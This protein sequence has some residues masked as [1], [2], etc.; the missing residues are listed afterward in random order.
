[1]VHLVD[2]REQLSWFETKPL[3][4]WRVLVPRTKDQAGDMS[5]RLRAY[6][7][8]P[9][10][11][12][13]DDLAVREPVPDRLLDFLAEMEFRTLA[14]RVA[15]KLGREAPAAALDPVAAPGRPKAAAAPL[16]VPK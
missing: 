8:V 16:P 9:V 7:A 3:F 5:E 10:E 11:V 15:A 12:P 1:M 2:L 13:L 4:G 6:G 14:T